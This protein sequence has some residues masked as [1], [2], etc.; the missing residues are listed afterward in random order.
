MTHDFINSNKMKLKLTKL[1][2]T[3]RKTRKGDPVIEILTECG[4]MGSMFD[5][6]ALTLPIGEE[7]ELDVSE[8]PDYNDEKRY[9][10]Q[11]PKS[12]AGGKFPVRDWTYDKRKE[13]LN[14]AIGS[15]KLTDQQVK[16]ENII[17]LAKKYYEYLNEK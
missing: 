12:Q 7:I 8:A 11:F 10:F 16:S 5:G 17:A 15:I 2:D 9:Y 4:K 6:K 1:I 13:S 3:G 14:A